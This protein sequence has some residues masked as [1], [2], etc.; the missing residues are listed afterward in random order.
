MFTFYI[1]LE[2]DRNGRQIP[3]REQ[4]EGIGRIKGGA[5]ECFH[6]FSASIVDG[7]WKNDKGENVNEKVLRLEL[8]ISNPHLT[9][10]NPL[11]PFDAAFSFAQFCA[12]QLNQE[13]VLLVSPQGDEFVSNPVKSSAE[14]ERNRQ[15]DL[16]S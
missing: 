9:P 16:G 13:S 7:G 6:G 1:G 11:N 14:L 3:S 8:S 5:L 2:S 12:V 15:S 4:S 10:G